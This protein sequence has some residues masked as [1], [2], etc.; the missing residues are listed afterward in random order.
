MIAGP[1][2]E[3]GKSFISTN[4]ATIF[5]QGD[6]RVLLIDADMRRGYMHKYFDVDVKPGLSELLSGQADLQKYYTKLK[7]LTLM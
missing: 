3:V 5:A 1:S 6:K 7:L 4:L 2:P